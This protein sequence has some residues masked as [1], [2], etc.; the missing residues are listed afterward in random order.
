MLKYKVLWRKVRINEVLSCRI[1]VE[2]GDEGRGSKGFVKRDG[3]RG[4]GLSFFKKMR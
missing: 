2:I 1:V 4:N 3:G